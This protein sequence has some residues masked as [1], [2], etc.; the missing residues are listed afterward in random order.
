MCMAV[1]FVKNDQMLLAA[2]RNNQLI[3]YNLETGALGNPLEWTVDDEGRPAKT[4]RRPSRVVMSASQYQLAGIYRGQDILV[5]DLSGDYGYET[6]NRDTGLSTSKDSRQNTT[7]YDMVFNPA[8]NST[9]FAVAYFEGD[10]VLFDT[11][12]GSQK[13]SVQ[14]N[15]QSLAVSPNGRTLASFDASGV[16]QVFDFETL[17]PIFRI[18]SRDWGIKALCF[19]GDGSRLLVGRGSQCK[20]WN[21]AA[22]RREDDEIENSD[23][24]SISTAAHEVQ[25]DTFGDEVLI[26]AICEY[27]NGAVF[28]CGKDDGS[29]S[30]YSAK[31]GKKLKFLYENPGNPILSLFVD[32]KSQTIGSSAA[33]GRIVAYRLAQVEDDWQLSDVQFDANLK[34]AIE[35]V[36]SNEGHTRLL[37]C[38]Q[39]GDVLYD[40]DHGRNTIVATRT[41]ASDVPHRWAALPNKRDL[42]LITD[43]HAHIFTWDKLQCLTGATGILLEGSDSLE[44]TSIVSISPC[45]NGLTI[46]IAFSHFYQSHTSRASVYLYP[47]SSFETSTSFSSPLTAKLL[48]NSYTLSSQVK[49]L[50]GSYAKC[51]VFLH[52]SGWIC[53]ADQESFAITRHFIVP[54]DWLSSNLELMIRVTETGDIL[55]VRGDEV[56]VIKRG[57]DTSEAGVPSR[58]GRRLVEKPGRGGGS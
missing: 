49:Y 50:I 9:L 53:S 51:L 40:M 35:Q 38:S 52:S 5:W 55:F 44:A 28:L 2:M 39:S 13:E 32:A 34:C 23:T 37:V 41:R 7:V 45:Y 26:T 27:A 43:H 21:P 25:F 46:A 15:A 19:N 10:I 1:L 18:Q 6:Y 57:L 56:A 47:T 14:A 11:A 8:P 58:V 30:L 24:V 29:V 36:L 16:V 42:I 33:S 3:E 20:I 22:L 4:F 31:D 12:D 17:N 48:P 54:T